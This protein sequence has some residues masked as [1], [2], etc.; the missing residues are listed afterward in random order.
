MKRNSSHSRG[1]FR[2]ATVITQAVV[3]GGLVGVGVAAMAVDTGLMY[4]AK[5]ELQKAADA[6]ALAA[7]SQLS[8]KRNVSQAVLSEASKFALANKITGTGAHMLSSD[9]AMGNAVLNA[10]TGKYD[11]TPNQA[12]YN[13]VNVKLRR[14]QTVSDGPISLAFGKM[15]G[16]NSASMHASATAMVTPRDISVVVD[17]SSAMNNDSEFRHYKNFTSDMGGTKSGTQINLEAVWYGLP[18][19]KGN[20]GVGN[21]LD[22]QPPGNPSNYNDQPGTGPGQPHS[23]GGNTSPGANPTHGGGGCGGPRW[24]WMTG[25]GNMIVLGSY[26]PV[27]DPGL[28]YIPRS[29]NCTDADVT[30]NITESGYSQPERNALLGSQFDG[31][32][33]HYHNRVKALIGVAGWKSGKNNGKYTTGGG[34]GDNKLDNSEMAQEITFP[35]NGGS[36]DGYI[37]YVSGSVSSEMMAT[38]PNFTYRYG[39]KTFVNYVVEMLGSN[40]QCPDLAN[41]PEMPLQVAKDTV[42]ALIDTINSL[43]TDDHVS[44]EVFGTTGKHEIDLKAPGPGQELASVL[45]AVPDTLNQRQANYYSPYANAGAGLDKAITELTSSRSRVYVG[46]VILYLSDGK[47][48]VNQSGSYV[49]NGA[50]SAVDWVMNRASQAASKGITI[51][52]VGMG[53]DVNASLLQQIATTGKGQYFFADNTVDPATG[54]PSYAEQLDTIFWGMD[55]TRPVRLIK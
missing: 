20:N 30:A 33:S 32:V 48:N 22:P 15:L 36:W 42:Q 19:Q 31:N 46:K 4:S 6:S 24:G 41:A 10:T 23:Q 51:H 17:L 2:R 29:T 39:L 16:V 45:Q 13:A 9:V 25:W 26:T 1:V 34:N 53:S 28:W 55:A 44:L 14:D 18:C 3:F 52:T 21:G 47:A 5:S 54:R 8:A 50:S 37:D 11:F 38:D 43:G 7:A 49:G 40:A 12:P 27:G 35:Y